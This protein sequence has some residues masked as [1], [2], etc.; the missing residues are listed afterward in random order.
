MEKPNVKLIINPMADMGNAWK[1][2]WAL[3]PVPHASRGFTGANPGSSC[4]DN[5]DFV[6]S[7]SGAIGTPISAAKSI[8]WVKADVLRGSFIFDDRL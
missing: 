4:A 5:I 8:R 3:R 7:L 1:H 6:W 2:A